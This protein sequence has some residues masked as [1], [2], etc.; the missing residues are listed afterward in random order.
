MLKGKKGLVLGLANDKSIAFAVAKRFVEEGAEVIGSY[1]N[2][3][4]KTFIEPHTKDLGI[5]L[6]KCDIE[7]EGDL[8][9]F[10]KTG[11]LGSARNNLVFVSPS[12]G[13]HSLTLQGMLILWYSAKAE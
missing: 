6:V 5:Q 10:V 4:S 11:L 9:N 12:S 2:D 8:E 3:K 7:Q 13:L 1:L